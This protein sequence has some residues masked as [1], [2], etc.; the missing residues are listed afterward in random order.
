MGDFAVRVVP[1][2]YPGHA[3]SNVLTRTNER[4]GEGVEAV[5]MQAA[6]PGLQG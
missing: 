2:Y 3:S 1:S 5:A 4:R 6:A